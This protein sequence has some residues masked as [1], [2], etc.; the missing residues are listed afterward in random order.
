MSSVYKLLT[1]RASTGYQ[2]IEL[3]RFSVDSFVI[4]RSFSGSR[5]LLIYLKLA[6]EGFG[7]SLPLL[8]PIPILLRL[9]I[10]DS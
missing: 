2:S 5:I 9:P 3:L 7:V 4:S 10:D 8:E 6:L 1:V